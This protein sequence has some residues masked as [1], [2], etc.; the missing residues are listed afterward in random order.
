MAM[1]D[2]YLQPPLSDEKLEEVLITCKDYLDR[3]LAYIEGHSKK[4]CKFILGDK[5]TKDKQWK[6]S[7]IAER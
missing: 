1:F 6:Y 2:L 4:G 3:T 7:N 5:V